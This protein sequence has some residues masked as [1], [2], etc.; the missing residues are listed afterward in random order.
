MSVKACIFSFGYGQFDL[1]QAQFC[2]FG[3]HPACTLRNKPLY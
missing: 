2:N 1:A 3:R